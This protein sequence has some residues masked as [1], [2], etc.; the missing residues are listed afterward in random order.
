MAI[1][2][3]RNPADSSDPYVAV[4][5]QVGLYSLNPSPDDQVFMAELSGREIIIPVINP[6]LQTIVDFIKV[7][8]TD[9]V[10]VGNGQ[11]NVVYNGESAVGSDCLG[12]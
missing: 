6:G 11:I 9:G 12:P 2:D 1:N 4:G 3:Y 8:V 7:T 10:D 5:K